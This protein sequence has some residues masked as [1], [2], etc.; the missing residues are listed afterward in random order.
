MTDGKRHHVFNINDY[1]PKRFGLNYN[2]PQIIIEYLTPSSGK[3]YHHRMRLHKFSKE[4]SNG[5]ILKELHDRHGIYLDKKKVLNEQLIKL[6]ERL[7]DNY[8]GKNK[9]KENSK[10]NNKIKEKNVEKLENFSGKENQNN[11][12]EKQETKKEVKSGF[13]LDEELEPEEEEEEYGFD[14]I[15][16]E[17]LNKLDD[18]A[19]NEKKS[20]MDKVFDKNYIGK[21]NKDFEY[22]IRKDFN[23][24]E[25]AAEWDEE[26][27]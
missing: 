15:N 2:P 1:I 6:I 17:D 20:E 4:K 8:K 26:S 5:E 23:H 10:E 3:L 27:Y 24:E 22:D 12:K 25:Y 19:L 13:K 18:E 14:D 11:N 16:D 21:D 9:K 7:K